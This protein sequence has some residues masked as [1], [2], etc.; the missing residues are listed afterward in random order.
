MGGLLGRYS[1]RLVDCIRRLLMIDPT[2]RPTFSQLKEWIN[3]NRYVVPVV[4]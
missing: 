1:D 3:N 4:T 2:L